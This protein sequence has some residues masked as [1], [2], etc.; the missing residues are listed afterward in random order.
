VLTG[1]QTGLID[2]VVT[3]PIGALALQWHTHIKYVT[4]QPINYL[5]ATMIVD[6]KFFNKISKPDQLVVREI[7]GEVYKKIDAQNRVDNIAAR[8]ALINQGIKFIKLSD[9]DKIEWEKIDD[10]VIGEMIKK[11]D[12]NKKLYDAV[13]VNKPDA[14]K[15][16]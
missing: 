10:F 15:L 8:Q 16:N 14:P 13:T 3:S 11:Y 7:M 1:L 4:D 9:E 5:V 12:Y 6:A 2:T